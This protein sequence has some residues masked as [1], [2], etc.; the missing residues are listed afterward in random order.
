MMAEPDES[1]FHDPDKG[2][3]MIYRLTNLEAP[4]FRLP[5]GAMAIDNAKKKIA[6]LGEAV[7]KYASWSDNLAFDV[8]KEKTVA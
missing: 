8:R 4:P 1:A 7:D 6:G 2:S 3:E 5:L